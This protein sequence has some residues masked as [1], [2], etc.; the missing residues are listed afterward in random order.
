MTFAA[1]FAVAVSFAQSGAKR[2]VRLPAHMAKQLPTVS[3]NHQSTAQQQKSARLMA[4]TKPILPGGLN[5][6][7]LQ[8]PWY[9][10]SPRKAMTDEPIFDQP[11]GELVIYTRS[12]EGYVGSWFGVLYSPKSAYANQV[13]LGSDGDIYVKDFMSQYPYGS[14]TKGKI[15]GSTVSFE[16]P[17]QI[18]IDG[19]TYYLW[20]LQFDASQST[21]VP[22]N[23]L[24][25]LTLNY[26]ADTGAITTP[27]GSKFASGNQLLG[28]TDETGGW[29]GYGDYAIEMEPMTD[30]PVE[31]PSDLETEFYSVQADGVSGSL[32][33][34]GFQGDEV[35]VQGLYS[36]MPD[37]WV[38]GKLYEN[39]EIVF[40]DA[41]YIGVDQTTNSHVY[42]MGADYEEVYYEDYG[43]TDAVYTINSESIVFDYDPETRTM[44]AQSTFVVNTGNMDTNPV[45][46][47]R[48][49]VMAPF[50]EVAATPAAPVWEGISELG[51]EYYNMG[52]GWGYFQFYIYNEDVDGNFILPGKMTYKVWARV[53]GEEMPLV[54]SWNDYIYQSEPTMSEIPLDYSD[55]WDID[56]SGT[57]H[58]IYFFQGGA[59]AYGV[60][61]IYRGGGEEHCSEI[62]WCE[63]QEFGTEIQPE[64]ATPDYPEVDP[65]NVGG[66]VTVSPYTGNES[67]VSYGKYDEQAYDVAMLVK[68]DALVGAHIDKI[69]IPVRKLEG[70]SGWKVWLSSQLRVEGGQNVPDLVSIDVEPTQT[71]YFTVTLPKPYIIPAEGVYVGYSLVTEADYEATDG[72]VGVIDQVKP[73]GF[74]LHT[75][76]HFL[77]WMEISA[78]TEK[79][80]LIEVS[81]SGSGIKQNA[82]SPQKN[83]RLY[84]KVGEEVQ[85][86]VTFVNHGSAGISSLDVEYDLDGNIL[87]EHYDLN[88]PVKGQIGATYD[89]N[90]SLPAIDTKGNYDLRVTVNNVNTAVN[91][92]DMPYA[93]SPVSALT[94]VPKHRTL[95]E[96]YTGLWCGWCPRGFVALELL[97]DQYPDEF[98]CVSYHNGDPMEI[99]NANSF[100]SPVSGFPG[101]WMDRGMEL[102][103][104]YGSDGSTPMGIIND[105]QWRNTMF[106][107]ADIDLAAEY[108]ADDN[109]VNVKADV[110][111]PYDA[112][113][114]DYA[115]EYIL[116][117]DGMTDPSWAQSNYFPD[118][119]DYAEEEGLDAFVDNDSEVYGLVYNDV[120]V[121][122]SEIGGIDESIP[123]SVTADEPVSH[124]Y[125][126]YLDYA[127]NTSYEPLIQD[128]EKL[129]MVAL[130]IDKKTGVVANAR[131][132]NVTRSDITDGIASADRGTKATSVEFFD[133]GGRKLDRM[134]SGA[135]IVRMTFAN[136]TTKTVKVMR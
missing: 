86:T 23:G 126:F 43:Y 136:G 95:L 118:Y 112:D 132:V 129:E 27:V 131:K 11:E 35:Y 56:V 68:D 117:E 21:Y 113:D 115:L 130:L 78:E 101:A 88:R 116:V 58:T 4:G 104:Y 119:P 31:A 134:Q 76:R 77:K 100:P 39:N 98:V 102:D 121:M 99:L 94:Y 127:W 46:T 24:T 105:L 97:A 40:D 13:V 38:K 61:V 18:D 7:R 26:N 52:Y 1:L 28:L 44:T 32:A 16:F 51:W 85:T 59:E 15:D 84:V 50:T 54:L 29:T 8:M 33:N 92:D 125:T 80:A 87:S 111:F 57:G 107:N 96:E 17:Q 81:V 110:T 6:G 37:A 9:R 135:N 63:M 79:S 83:D 128:T 73:S 65:E 106:A 42:L 114:N 53:N 90:V 62:A 75:S 72:P 41:Q 3:V 123:T 22:V 122:M 124:E 49:A 103:P 55:G 108:V 109:T 69:T 89:V 14:W 120:A 10:Q 2:E 70:I 12:N 20:L 45:A 36:A 66:T 47:Y 74:Y 48:N 64:A 82:V 60:Q 30:E 67:R 133:L 25:T 91:E 93:I 71:G 34:V 5:K 19:Y